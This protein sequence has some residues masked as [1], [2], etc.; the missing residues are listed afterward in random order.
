MKDIL[1]K[2]A[3]ATILIAGANS[4][5][6]QQDELEEIW[7][8]NLST[9][10]KVENP[11][12]RPVLGVSTGFLSF[13]GDL[14]NQGNTSLLGNKAIKIN[15][16]GY[17]DKKRN[18]KWNVFWLNGEI[19]GQYVQNT[20]TFGFY[21]F[22]TNINQFGANVEY[23]F[24]SL[25]KNSRFHPYISVGFAPLNF[26]P[27][28]D[29]LGKDGKVYNASTITTPDG[30]Y[31]TN[32]QK[33]YKDLNYSANTYT[34]PIDLGFDFTLHDRVAL[35]IG[36]TY[37]ITF[38]DEI[39]NISDKTLATINSGTKLPHIPTTLKPNSQKDAYL[40]T[41]I[42]LNF[43]IFSDRKSYIIKKLVMDIEN[44][45]NLQMDQDGDG[46]LDP[47]DDCPDTPPGVKVNE[48]NGCPL[49]TDAD[50][51]PDYMDTDNRTPVGLAVN[52]KGVALSKAD[53]EILDNQYAAVRREDA[54]IF[55][56]KNR[57]PS[58]KYKAKAQ[59]PE[60]FVKVDV[61]KDGDISYDELKRAVENFLD[62]QSNFT[63][64]E[65]SDLYEY[66]FAQ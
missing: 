17:V 7:R 21:N 19:S 5:F 15:L 59:M 53:F 11:T 41:Y 12:Y 44:E 52:N 43:D 66:F 9:E 61:N 40:F 62:K 33:Y 45:P 54:Q 64:D 4:A 24:N 6:A 23:T 27:M 34:V 20:G 48:N 51:I 14:Q 26:T 36:T 13:W 50:G 58:G 1:K 42:G 28:G 47:G 39:D 55:L 57:T 46:V 35:R 37:N 10:V 63:A 32:L 38:S 16:S 30:I 29:I 3:I 65:V 56:S 18:I 60:K 31:E 2:I 22:R 25:F 49:D 8:K